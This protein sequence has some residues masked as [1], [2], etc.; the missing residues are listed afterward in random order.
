M[1]VF[2]RFLCVAALFAASLTVATAAS[3]CGIDHCTSCLSKYCLWCED[4]YYASGGACVA[5]TSNC[6]SCSVAGR[7]TSCMDGYKLSYYKSE[8]MSW[9]V[10]KYGSCDTKGPAA[11]CTDPKCTS[12]AAGTCLF[13]ANG[14]YLQDGK[15]VSCSAAHCKHCA[16]AGHC[17]ACEAGYR[18]EYANTTDSEIIISRWGVCVNGAA[19]PNAAAALI[20]VAV[21]VLGV[22][23][24]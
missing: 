13:C 11:S 19:F 7:C 16:L 23:S 3:S 5:C 21:A 10:V 2:L 8:N 15:C 9:D 12:C 20:G 24:L 22:M 18:L 6:R 14:Y 1:R 17:V 4:G